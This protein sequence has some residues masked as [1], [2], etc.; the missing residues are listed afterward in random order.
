[1]SLSALRR[2]LYETWW[3]RGNAARLPAYPEG[4]TDAQF[5]AALDPAQPGGI[6]ARVVAQTAAVA[7]AQ[8][9][10]P[11]GATQADLAQAITTYTA[12]HPLPPG[13]ELKRSDLPPFRAAA[14]PVVVVAGARANAFA[15]DLGTDANG[16]L[17]CRFVDQVVTGLVVT[18]VPPAVPVPPQSV[19]VTAATLAGRVPMVDLTNLPMIPGALLTEFLLL[20]PANAATVVMLGL[21]TSDPATI[22]QTAAAMTAGANVAGT[23]PAILPPTW[24]QPWA[25]LF[26]EWEVLFYPIP[27]APPSQPG[28]AAPGPWSFDGTGYT[29]TGAGADTAAVISLSGRSVLTPQPAFT[30]KSRLDSYLA[31]NPGMA[32]SDLEAF[33]ASID[34]WD[35]LSQTLDGFNTLLARR[36]PASGS[37]RTPRPSSS[38]PPRPSPRSWGRTRPRGRCRAPRVRSSAPG[39]RPGSSRCARASSCSA[40]RPSSTASA[41]APTS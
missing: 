25:P 11:W 40:G 38:R 15:D 5:A 33:V 13:T 29:W 10:I 30:F 31:S 36:D 22:T 18:A 6:A 7:A 27:Y 16:L 35:F 26:L 17:P 23:P 41:R 3:K 21:G 9:A 1:M 19:T 12:T 14:D 2:E 32:L 34:G 4:L 28:A 37:R 8:A 20:D 39:R 24:T